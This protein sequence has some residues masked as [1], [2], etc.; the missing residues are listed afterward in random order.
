MAT[1]I[2]QIAVAIRDWRAPRGAPCESEV[3]YSDQNKTMP[4]C[5]WAEATTKWQFQNLRT[6]SLTLRSLD[7]KN[8]SAESTFR[9]LN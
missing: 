4:E 5:D 6:R 2:T 9:L 1:D 3:P 8:R 7:S